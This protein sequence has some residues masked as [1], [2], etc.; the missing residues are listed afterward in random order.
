MNWHAARDESYI[1]PIVKGM[2]RTKPKQRARK[3]VLTDEEIRALW[4]VLDDWD[5]EA[6]A[7]ARKAGHTNETANVF[8]ALVRCLFLSAQRRDEVA[9]MARAELDGSL[10]T[11]PA[12]RHKTGDGAGAKIVPLSRLTLA[13]VAK[14]G[15]VDKCD[16]VFTTNGKTPY[17]GFSKGK[18]EL[19][20]A[21][22]TKLRADATERHDE[23]A[24]ARADEVALLLVAA[25]KGD[26]KAR[27]KLNSAWWTLHDLRRTGKTLMARAGVSAFDSERVL[28]HAIAGVEGVYDRYDYLEE[29]RRALEALAGII[30]QI[31]TAKPADVVPFIRSAGRTT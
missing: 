27:G 19:D 15:R 14:V 16:L 8:G 9:A 3:R 12:S 25:R 21:M 17:S 26:K 7:A 1:S 2:A 11:I 31:A 4:A 24:L 22:L 18:R 10:W 5:E 28:G 30:T 20:E 13:V 6:T 23:A 29:K